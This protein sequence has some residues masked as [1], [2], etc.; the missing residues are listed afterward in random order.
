MVDIGVVWVWLSIL[1]RILQSW[2]I[3][4]GVPLLTSSLAVNTWSQTAI[5]WSQVVTSV[6]ALSTLDMGTSLSAMHIHYI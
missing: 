1:L 6:A 3:L 4:T 5:G 2:W